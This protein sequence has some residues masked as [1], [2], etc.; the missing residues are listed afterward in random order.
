MKI[1]L[2]DLTYIDEFDLLKIILSSADRFPGLYRFSSS[3]KRELESDSFMKALSFLEVCHLT[4]KGKSWSKS[5]WLEVHQKIF[6]L[7]FGEN[8]RDSDRKDRVAGELLKQKATDWYNS[9]SSLSLAIIETNLLVSEIEIGVSYYMMG[10]LIR[11]EENCVKISY[12]DFKQT[13]HTVFNIPFLKVKKYIDETFSVSSLGE[14][15]F[16]AEIIADLT[17]DNNEIGSLK[18]KDEVVESLLINFSGNAPIFASINYREELPIRFAKLLGVS[19][20]AR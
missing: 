5:E 20:V 10:S 7:A 13:A 2:K 3:W 9:A 17:F 8:S 6:S 14:L 12:N 11:F 18:F 15:F 16:R 19:N 4:Y 1:A